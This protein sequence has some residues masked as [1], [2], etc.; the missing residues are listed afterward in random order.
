MFEEPLAGIQASG[1]SFQN[2]VKDEFGLV[3]IEK[4]YTPINNHLSEL[5]QLEQEALQEMYAIQ[6]LLNEARSIV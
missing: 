2:N 3:A 1:I 6:Q 5:F 4:I